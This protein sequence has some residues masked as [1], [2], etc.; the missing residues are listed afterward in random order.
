MIDV[1]EDAVA[2]ING[3][4]IAYAERQ[5]YGYRAAARANSRNG[6]CR[7]VRPERAPATSKI[8]NLAQVTSTM[9]HL[10]RTK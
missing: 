4:Q 1:G 2:G 7:W 6:A 9:L 5:V 3:G 8:N 10:C